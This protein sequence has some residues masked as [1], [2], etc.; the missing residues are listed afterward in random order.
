MVPQAGLG[1]PNQSRPLQEPEVPDYLHR[2]IERWHGGKIKNV[3]GDQRKLDWSSMQ[4]FDQNY[5]ILLHPIDYLPKD[6]DDAELAFQIW[7]KCKDRARVLDDGMNHDFILTC[8][9]SDY[10]GGDT[11]ENCTIRLMLN[12]EYQTWGAQDHFLAGRYGA[13]AQR[14]PAP[15]MMHQ[16]I[17]AMQLAHNAIRMALDSQQ[18]T[19]ESQERTIRQY[20]DKE[21]NVHQMQLKASE[22][23]AKR[24]YEKLKAEAIVSSVREIGSRVAA[25]LPHFGIK[26]ADIAISKMTGSESLT[27]RTVRD[28]KA[29]KT[30]AIF[31]DHLQQLS[32]DPNAIR[33]IMREKF[34][35]A[36]DSPIYEHLMPVLLE[37]SIER[38]RKKAEQEARTLA[39][40]VISPKQ[41]ATPVQ[42]QAAAPTAPAFELASTDIFRAVE[43]NIAD[44][45]TLGIGVETAFLFKLSDPA[46]SWLVTFKNG[47]R[48]VTRGEGE[49]DVTFALADAD[50]VGICTG[51]ADPMS[52]FA[53]GKLKI[54][55]DLFAARK[56]GVLRVNETYLRKAHDERKK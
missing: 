50:L 51:K 35:I 33:P 10:N 11:F 24:E 25:V 7:E 22:D 23:L 1:P 54:E 52:L 15:H 17:E 56:L 16:E 18:R 40:V 36:E 53:N 45:Q 34:G 55:G 49:A 12:K 32:P 42:A 20:A 14:H 30:I 21:F 47:T 19:I 48:T 26:M 2:A 5:G 38:N 4:L 31:A 37:L 43:M 8:Y 13:A 39:S 27:T 28:E 9:F 29:F 6:Q 3:N 41:A 46:A 44:D